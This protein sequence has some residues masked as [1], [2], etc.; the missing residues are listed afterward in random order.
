MTSRCRAGRFDCA[1]GSAGGHNGLLDIQAAARAGL[2]PAAHPASMRQ[3]R[4][5]QKNYVLES[6]TAEQKPLMEGA[7]KKSIEAIGDR[8]AGARE[9]RRR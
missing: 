2:Q 7:F 9:S 6:F 3:G 5:P 8:C 1:S 4:V